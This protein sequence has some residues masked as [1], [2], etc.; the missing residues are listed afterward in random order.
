MPK[1]HRHLRDFKR[2]LPATLGA[3]LLA[4]TVTAGQP[5]PVAPPA[6]PMIPLDAP[7]LAAAEPMLA[8]PVTEGPRNVPVTPT[9]PSHNVTINLIRRM[10]K[11]GLLTQEEADEM[12]QQAEQEAQM[13][14]EQTEAIVSAVER[15]HNVA[16]QMVPDPALAAAPGDE[17]LRVTYIPETV[18][19]EMAAQ[20]KQDLMAE[21]RDGN[22]VEKRMAPEWAMRLRFFGDVRVRGES[23]TFPDGNDNTGSFPNFNSINT[24]APFDVSGYV[25]S[26]QHNVDQ[27]RQRLRLRA[28]L[29]LE[30]DLANGFSAGLRIATGENNSPVSTNQS[31]GLSN[32]GQGGQFSKYAIWLDRGFLKYETG[33]DPE[34]KVALSL[35]RFDNPFFAT[36]AVWDD[37]LGFDGV[38]V[39]GKYRFLKGF[40]PFVT[41]GAFPV[42]NTDFNFGTNNPAKFESTDKWLYAVQTGFDWRVKKDWNVKFGAAY[43][44]FDGV[45]G[46]LSDP[47]TPLSASDQGNTDNTRPSFAQKGNTY[48]A[49]RNIVPTA[50]NNYGTTNQYQY[51]GLATP[52]EELSLTARI[53]YSR[54]E[55]YKL[56]ILGEFTKNLAFDRDGIDRIAVNNRGPNGENGLNSYEGGD[57]AWF[58]ET[59]FGHSTMDKF[60]KWMLGANYRYIESD[61]VVDGFNDSDFGLGGT[62]MQGYTVYGSL[63]LSP[64]V[65]FAMRYMSAREIAGAP[66]EADIFQLD[67]NGKF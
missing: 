4:H 56:S 54:W 22:F 55:P 27:D 36:E 2:C 64:Y 33:H 30:A 66:F 57:T 7:L 19:A 44:Y 60:G 62:N 10:V 26:P 50:A 16:Q 20:I 6:E 49:L 40:I 29:G 38:A 14:R 59:R 31:M 47:F 48:R 53:D 43:Y 63:A 65:T 24:G 46:E 17:S 37:D 23:V 8:E 15:V 9:T 35:G 32:Q 13:A 42:F 67:F 58:V 3:A 51:F 41:A 45:H 25:F 52:F 34:R 18:K 28:R 11:K 61:A 21:A 39:H 5:A 1:H 12:I